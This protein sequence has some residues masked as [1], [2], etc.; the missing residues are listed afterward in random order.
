LKLNEAQKHEPKPKERVN[1]L[2]RIYELVRGCATPK[3][4]EELK[5]ELQ[6]KLNLQNEY[7]RIIMETEGRYRDCKN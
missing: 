3:Q 1:F 4:F 7:E 2:E 5:E 6:H